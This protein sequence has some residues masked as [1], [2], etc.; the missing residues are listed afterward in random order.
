[1]IAELVTEV[2]GLEAI[3]AEWDELAVLA[4]EP[5]ATPAWVFGWLAHVAPDDVEPRV[6]AVRDRKRLV[7]LAPFYV[8]A[9]APRHYRIMADDFSS[10]VALPAAPEREWEAARVVAEALAEAPV[11]P[12]RLSLLPLSAGSAWPAA[13]RDGWPGGWRPSLQEV[14]R[15][16]AATAPLHGTFDDY[17]AARGSEFRR[18]VRRRT[19]ALEA[20][21]GSMRISTAATVKEDIAAFVRL[22]EARWSD[23]GES[24]LVQLGERLPALLEELAE[25]LVESARFRLWMVELEGKAICADLSLVAGGEIVGV[26]TGWDEEHKKLAPAQIVTIRKIEDAYERGEKRLDMGWGSIAY[27][28]AFATGTDP[29]CWYSMV[30]PGPRWPLERATAAG[31]ALR[32]R[33]RLVA[34]RNL[35]SERVERLRKVVTRVKPGGDDRR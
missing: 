2:A 28:R 4:E 24:R 9:G 10:S 22:H 13:L 1:M 20:D 31:P 3:A 19:R 12:A 26:N 25:R 21:G 34:R 6:V 27:K 33:A 23:R 18:T 32:H 30:A 15:E 7:A 29:V 11:P 8:R 16:D 17:M 14:R 5:M 35:D